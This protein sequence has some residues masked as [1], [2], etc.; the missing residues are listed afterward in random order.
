MHRTPPNNISLSASESDLTNL[1][2]ANE[3]SNITL[4]PSVKRL[5]TSEESVSSQE[6]TFSSFKKEIMESMAAMFA[7]QN[8]KFSAIEKSIAEIKSQ[9]TTIHQTNCEI[10]RSLE[11]V[12]HQ[13]DDVKDKISHLEVERKKMSSEIIS[14]NNKIENLECINKKTSVEIRNVPNSKKRESK[15]TLF[16]MIQHLQTGISL[17]DEYCGQIR[18]VYR[19]NYKSQSNVSTVVIEFMTTLA[20]EK[21]ISKTKLFSNSKGDQTNSKLMGLDGASTPIYISEHLSPRTR[22]L[23]YLAREFAKQN[24]Y[25]YCW[26][27]GGKVF[28]RKSEGSQHL[29]VK[30]DNDLKSLKNPVQP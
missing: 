13:I 27:S 21:F 9:N 29:L 10:E 26:T 3:T 8:E 12:S 24:E 30:D 2:K 6:N 15:S 16:D 4:R 1:S 7:E 14:I 25:K 20:K 17:E 19:T 5:R 28:L 11:F 22:K 23:F 18:D